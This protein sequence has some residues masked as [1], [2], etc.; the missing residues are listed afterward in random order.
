MRS[1]SVFILILGLMLG[2][3]GISRA[4]APLTL[5]PYTNQ[6]RYLLTNQL[7]SATWFASNYPAANAWPLGS[8]VLGFPADEPMPVGVPT[9]GNPILAT[10]FNTTFIT[11]FYFR[12]S[13]TLTTNPNYLIITGTVVVDDG[14]VIYVNGREVQRLGVAAGAVTYNTFANRGGEVTDAG[15]VETFS[16]ASSNFVQGANVIAVS[17]HQQ[18]IGS[19]DVVFGMQMT[20][21]L[22]QPIT[23][24][25]QPQDQT[26][27][28][29]LPATFSV[30]VTGTNPRYQWY[31]NNL[32]VLN[33][34]NSTY[35]INATNL[36]MSGRI[37]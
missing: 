26:V 1:K 32:P 30:T 3:I 12:T 14:A 2:A 23:I 20:A 25:S 8:G 33:Q 17:V 4:Q 19:S 15:R 37:V 35:T 5:M 21:Q 16:I 24:T 31:N 11:S 34:T 27:D 29:G 13:I 10:N 6:W 36:A 7:P 18:A 9:P 28:V 22:L